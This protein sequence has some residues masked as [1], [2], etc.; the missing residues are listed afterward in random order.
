MKRAIA[1]LLVAGVSWMGLMNCVGTF[2]LTGRLNKWVVGLKAKG[3]LGWKLISWIVFL[4]FVVI[5]PVYGIAVLLDSLIFNSME[6]WTDS[7]PMAY[8][9]KG[10]A[11]KVA[12][13]GNEKAIYKYTQHGQQLQISL[14][15]NGKLLKELVL[16]KDEPG[17]FYALVNGNLVPIHAEK[18]EGPEG[19][20]YRVFEGDREVNSGVLSSAQ[21]SVM[22][23]KIQQA[24]DSLRQYAD[25]GKAGAL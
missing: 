15:K 12:E 3:G 13:K 4:V 5:I 21:I 16:K 14:Y 8:N 9:E 18:I 2:A 11:T 19:T 17:V 24:A 10:E 23:A 7:N 25:A 22:N 1:L 20:Q 6:F